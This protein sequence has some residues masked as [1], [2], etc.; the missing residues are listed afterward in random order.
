MVLW[1][2][3]YVRAR[4]VWLPEIWSGEK[5][6]FEALKNKI[7]QIYRGSLKLESTMKIVQLVNFII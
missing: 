2:Y 4:F 6:N 3:E 1:R 5:K 7:G